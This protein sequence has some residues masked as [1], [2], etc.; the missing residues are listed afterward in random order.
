VFLN[1]TI[2]DEFGDPVTGALPT[3]RPASFWSL[4]SSCATCVVH[5]DPNLAFNHTWHD[6]SQLP[7]EAP[8]SLTLEFVG[9]A[10]HVFCILPPITPNVVTMY[11]LNFT[12]D[13]A[14]RGTFSKSPTSMTEFI[15]NL[16]VLFLDSLP[17]KPHTL[18][19]S[20]DDSVDGSIFLFDYA[21][22]TCVQSLRSIAPANPG[23][24]DGPGHA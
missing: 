11:N 23:V 20:T 12:L 10:I 24:Q 18:L 4:N 14:S 6:S 2:D 15:Y 16:P 19:I 13:G 9:T 3:Y 17:N 1:Q 21:V 8:V 5:P 7:G 22:Y